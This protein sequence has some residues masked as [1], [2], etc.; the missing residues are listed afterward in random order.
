MALQLTFDAGFVFRKWS[1]WL[2]LASAMC[3]AGVSTYAML[4]ADMQEIMPSWLKAALAIGS[5]ASAMLVPVATSI[6]QKSIPSA[7]AQE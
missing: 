3:A 7:R 2:A 1:T 6:Q 5:V 4:P